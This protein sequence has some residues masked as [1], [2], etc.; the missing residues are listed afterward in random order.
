MPYTMAT[1]PSRI[2]KLPAKDRRKWMA[3]F[4]SAYA[5]AKK[6]KMK[7]PEAYA[8]AV[9]NAAIKKGEAKPEETLTFD[10]PDYQIVGASTMQLIGFHGRI[11]KAMLLPDSDM[12][13]LRILHDLVVSVL[14]VR[15]VKHRND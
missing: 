14:D 7:D 11:H 2:K 15:G 13:K 4:N 10:T 1:L 12:E 6:K 9:A 3:V 8:Y 5:Y